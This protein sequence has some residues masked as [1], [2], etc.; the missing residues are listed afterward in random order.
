MFPSVLRMILSVVSPF[1]PVKIRSRIHIIAGGRIPC[2]QIGHSFS[3]FAVNK[4]FYIKIA[5]AKSAHMFFLSLR[6]R[7]FS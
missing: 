1:F 3:H 4:G 7:L 6:H 5:V 2:L